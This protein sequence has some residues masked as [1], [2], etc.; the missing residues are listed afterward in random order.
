MKDTKQITPYRVDY[1][2]VLKHFQTTKKGLSK[3]IANNR[4]QHFG[5]NALSEVHRQSWGIRYLKQF[6][7][8]MILLLL[9][10]SLISFFIGDQRTAFVLFAL[11]IFNTVIGFTQEYKAERI[12]ESLVKLVVPEAKVMRDNKLGLIPSAEIVPGDIIYIEEGDSIPAD[13]R[14]FEETE[15]STNDFALTGESNP[16]RKFTH[17]ISV[18][19][20]LGRRNN[21]C[22]MGTTVAT[23]N[24]YGVVVGTGMNTELGRIASLSQDTASDISPLQKEINTI[25]KYVTGGTV[26][27]C[28]TLLPIAIQADLSIKD[29]FLFA[30]GIASSIIPQG[31]PAEINTSLAQ[32]ANKLARAR[33][34]VKRLSAVETLGATSIICTDKTGTLTKNQMSVSQ[35]IVDSST[36]QVTGSGYETNG[37]IQ[38]SSKDLTN[39]QLKDLEL[40][41]VAGVFASNARVEPPD[42]KH[43]SWYAIGDPTEAS[44]ITLARKAKIDTNK[45]LESSP[46]LREFSFDSGRKR[47]S[48]IRK[49]GSNNEHFVFTKGAPESVL[50]KC[51]HI[52]K[53]GTIKKL[54]AQDKQNVLAEAEELAG[55]AMRNLAVAYKIL[56]QSTKPENISMEEAESDLV[57]LGFA[58]MIDPLRDE[59]PDA[60]KSAKQAHIA[61]SIITGDNA[62]TAQAIALKAG[63]AKDRD[64]IKLVHGEEVNQL[65][66]QDILSMTTKG[67]VI[68]SR[69]SPEDKLRIVGLI[70][71]SGRVVAVTGD[72]INDAPAL[73]RADI[74]VAMGKTGTDVAKQS[75]DIVL[76]DDSFHTLVGAVQQ[77]RIVFQNIKKGTLSCFTSNSAELIVNLTSLATTS[78][79]GIPLALTVM[80]ILAIDLIAELFPIASLGW[81]KADTN[82]MSSQPRNPKSHILN[83]NS[84]ADLLMCGVL[85]GGLA[86]MNYLW[87][88]G[89]HGFDASSVQSGSQIHMQATALTYLTIVLCQLGNI[90]QRRSHNGIF[91]KYQL[92]N[93]HFWIA[94]ALSLFCVINI[95]HNPWLSSYFGASSISI[96]DWSFAI[97]ALIIFLGIRELERIHFDRQSI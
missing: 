55:S 31:L 62:I 76:L 40:F 78:L 12:M 70:K 29:A 45:L 30:I 22:F 71:E 4:L 57:Y 36:Y 68:F 50:E 66:D 58:S 23:G 28:A 75:A 54:S 38:Q 61:V 13:I 97:G 88:F 3:V 59:V 92:H 84:I 81:D 69:V 53:N 52:L 87:F 32:A 64:D 20:T 46:E 89:R 37:A 86:F 65:S 95:I 72:G 16:T 35:I 19:T 2:V 93:K 82:L 43:N 34:L 6:L 51:N 14:L 63:L 15:L 33:A 10:S 90:I 77:G 94:I 9:A 39:K 8:F 24:G 47:M 67:S 18:N 17:P 60:M 5:Q 56:P 96:V 42:D 1:G 48:S 49:W 73:K 79:L 83:R 21:L 91:T 44:L 74:G 80:Q 11:I 41:F 85:I 25:A 7:D 27:L 26:I